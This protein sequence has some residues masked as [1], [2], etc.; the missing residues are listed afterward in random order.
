[1]LPSR[2]PAPT[3]SSD[4]TYCRSIDPSCIRDRFDPA[5]IAIMMVSAPNQAWTRRSAH[6]E[7]HDQAP[8]FSPLQRPDHPRGQRDNGRSRL[9]VGVPRRGR[10]A[11]ALRRDQYE[12]GPRHTLMLICSKTRC[13]QRCTASSPSS[14][15]STPTRPRRGRAATCVCTRG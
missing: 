7:R 1:M 10:A 6:V 2:R 13:G 14:C 5:S 12:V 4:Q 8:P 9:R 15:R 11:P 3:T